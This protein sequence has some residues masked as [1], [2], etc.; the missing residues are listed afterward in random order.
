MHLLHVNVLCVNS[1]WR[2]NKCIYTGITFT[3]DTVLIVENQ[4]DT[5]YYYFTHSISM[6]GSE[7][8]Y[9]PWLLCCNESYNLPAQCNSYI[10]L[11]VLFQSICM[12]AVVLKCRLINN[13][14]VTHDTLIQN[15]FKK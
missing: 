8:A 13:Y 15:Q 1:P 14:L 5:D 3:G 6:G 9:I 11:H 12:A 2:R 7:L 10:L 4:M